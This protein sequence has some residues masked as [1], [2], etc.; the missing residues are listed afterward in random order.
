MN[1]FSLSPLLQMLL[2]SNVAS[3]IVACS[4]VDTSDGIDEFNV[5]INLSVDTSYGINESNVHIG[6]SVERC[7]HWTRRFPPMCQRWERRPLSR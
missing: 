2:E 4:S 7:A 6:P 5:H 1:V 3:K